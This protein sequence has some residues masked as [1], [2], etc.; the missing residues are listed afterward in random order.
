VTCE[1]PRGP[2]VDR[3]PP[4]AEPL[5]ALW[6]PRGRGA[7]ATIHVCA[8]SDHWLPQTPIPFRAANGLPVL[9]QAIG[10]IVF[11]RWG[12]DAPEEIVVCRIDADTLEIHCHGGEAAACRI[13]ADLERAGCR[14]VPWTELIGRIDGQLEAELAAALSKATTMRT[15]AILLAQSQGLLR[16][17]CES[18]LRNEPDSASL[19]EKL[20]ALLRWADFG[21]HLTRPWKVVLAGRPNVG[22]SSL[23]NA[24]LGYTRSIVFDQPGTTRDVVTAV[25]VLDGWPIEISDTAGI[26]E[27]SDELESAGVRRAQ[28]NLGEADLP[29]LLIDFSAAPHEADHALLAAYPRAIVVAHKCDLP[30]YE[31]D[32][33]WEPRLSQNWIPISSKTG[34]GIGRLAEAIVRRLVPDLPSATT[35]IPITSRQIALLRHA[36][37]A[38]RTGDLETSRQA[39]REILS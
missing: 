14:I 23:M 22:K 20:A 19:S 9:Q 36:A 35:P 15:A 8:A 17:G 25:T 31:G 32:G 5:A 10:R 27:S 24:L 12:D 7:I 29:I 16:A 13:L 3:S 38:A 30:Q 11:G 28:R 26:R 37:D 6:T 18:L 34:E 21:L 33:G 1:P 4:R 2:R 39:I